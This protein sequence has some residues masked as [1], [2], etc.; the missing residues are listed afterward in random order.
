MDIEAIRIELGLAPQEFVKA[1]GVSKGYAGDLRSGR[2][3]VSLRVARKLEA[4]TG[5]PYLKA[6]IAA[7]VKAAG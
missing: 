3:K 5:K 7:K 6:A 1:L 2:R 4:L